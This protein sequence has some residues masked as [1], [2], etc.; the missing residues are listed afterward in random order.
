VIKHLSLSYIVQQLPTT[1]HQMSEELSLLQSVLQEVYKRLDALIRQL[2][3]NVNVKRLDALIRQLQVIVNV[4]RLDA[5]IRQLQVLLTLIF[6]CNC[7]IKASSLLTLIFTCNCLI[8]ASSLLTL[9]ITCNCLIKASSLLTVIKH[10]SLSYIVQQL[11]TTEH[12]MSEELS[13]LQSVL[14]E[15]YK[16]LDE[17]LAYPLT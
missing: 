5:L 16:S 15:V 9:T 11:P 1:E 4:K 13:L 14:Q 6:T 10:L 17:S 12:Q 2:Q 7:L 3:V 8:K